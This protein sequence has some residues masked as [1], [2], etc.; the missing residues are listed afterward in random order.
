[1]DMLPDDI[2]IFFAQVMRQ[3]RDKFPEMDK[4]KENILLSRYRLQLFFG[5]P[6]NIRSYRN[7]NMLQKSRISSNA[8]NAAHS[9]NE[10]PNHE[11]YLIP[12]GTLSRQLY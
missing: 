8:S 7:L 6:I 2:V 5:P 9:I 10:Q 11:T 3:A 1:M 12:A 4:L